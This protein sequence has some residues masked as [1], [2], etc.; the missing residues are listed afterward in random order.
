MT[1]R[2]PPKNIPDK[3]LALFGKERDI[4]GPENTGE[5]YKKFGPYAYI[6]GKRES[7]WKALFK[8]KTKK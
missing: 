1:I 2:R 5:I 4:T 3:I 8:K 7:F 6:K